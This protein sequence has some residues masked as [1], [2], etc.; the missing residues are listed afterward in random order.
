MPANIFARAIGRI[1]LTWISEAIRLEWM[2][3]MSSA[4]E[5]FAV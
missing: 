5:I 3:F 2:E 1:L 4:K